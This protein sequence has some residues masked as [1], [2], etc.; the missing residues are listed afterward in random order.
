[1]GIAFLMFCDY[2]KL[3]FVDRNVTLEAFKGSRK[4]TVYLMPHQV[5]FLSKD[6]KKALRSFTM[7]FS[8][9]K[10]CKIKLPKL[11]P[12]YIKGQI[13]AEP[14]GGWIGSTIFKLT[15]HNGGANEFGQL[16]LRIQA[17]EMKK[18]SLVSSDQVQ[19][20]DSGS[21]HGH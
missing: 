3:S 1:M 11:R 17:E 18:H 14:N 6:L 7:P 5:V 8:Q 19:N 13:E 15:F 20:R 10:D 9:I 16:M 2:V 21:Q 12:G 4:G